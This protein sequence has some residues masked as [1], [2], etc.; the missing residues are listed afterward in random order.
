MM[1]LSGFTHADERANPFIKPEPPKKE[2]VQDEELLVDEE[3]E[4]IQLINS[5]Y[6]TNT[7]VPNNDPMFEPINEF[8]SRGYTYRGT[9]NGVD[10]YFDPKTKRYFKDT[11]KIMT[12]ENINTQLPSV[13][14]VNY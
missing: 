7:T 5:M 8:L 3:L 4:K 13:E 6:N 9:M 14:Q 2:V 1:S 11:N 12:I 10:I